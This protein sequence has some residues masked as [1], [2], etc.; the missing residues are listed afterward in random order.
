LAE[1]GSPELSIG[2]ATSTGW[3]RPNVD[4]SRR[5][6]FSAVVVAMLRSFISWGAGRPAA[7][8]FQPALVG[9]EDADPD[10]VEAPE[11]DEI[12]EL[13]LEHRGKVESLPSGKDGAK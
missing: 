9:M 13:D 6:S 4:P 11:Q 8:R 10:R 5:N 3:H 1:E 7:G 2:F 12:D